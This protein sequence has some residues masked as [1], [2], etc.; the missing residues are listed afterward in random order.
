MN[1]TFWFV[2]LATKS[3]GGDVEVHGWKMLIQWVCITAKQHWEFLRESK[4]Y[5]GQLANLPDICRGGRHHLYSVGQYPNLPS[6]LERHDF[7]FQSLSSTNILE[8]I[9]QKKGH[10]H[11]CLQDRQKCKI[12]RESSST[13]GILSFFKLR[14]IIREV[15]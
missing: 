11:L 10:Q 1:I 15:K 2:P 7:Y 12:Y 4:S 9:V 13:G 3:H 6:A 5:N 14:N 8:K